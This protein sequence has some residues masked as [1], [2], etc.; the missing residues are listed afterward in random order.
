MTTNDIQGI[1]ALAIQNNKA[2]VIRAMN[3]TGNPVSTIITDAVLAE[4]LW[5]VFAAKG[6]PGLKDVLSRVE[7]DPSGITDA[8]AEA[9]SVKFQTA[10][11]ARGGVGDWLKG[12]GS[13]FGDLLG[14]STVS[15]GNVTSM[16][17]ESVLSPTMITLIVVIG[18]ILVVLLRKFVAV[19]VAIIVIVLA[20]VLYGIFA[21]K[22]VTTQTGG[23]TTSHG[24][25][26]QVI[27][28]W[29]TGFG[30]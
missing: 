5:N 3:T 17:S 18:L 10:P 11:F 4:K 23:G 27:L 29:L 8:E 21:K 22:I 14:G 28:T 13:Y 26:G 6:L 12:V 25:I 1:I 9:L 24:G 16:T 15:G 19:V 2:G 7:V 20:L 30:G